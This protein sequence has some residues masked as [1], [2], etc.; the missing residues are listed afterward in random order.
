MPALV[1]ARAGADDRVAV[2]DAAL[3]A[4]TQVHA[5]GSA[6]AAVIASRADIHGQRVADGDQTRLHQLPL[7]VTM[8][9][10]VTVCAVWPCSP[11][12]TA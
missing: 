1:G 2:R 8:S 7:A 12:A 6:R 5:L 9:V 4:V 11:S 3:A 10:A